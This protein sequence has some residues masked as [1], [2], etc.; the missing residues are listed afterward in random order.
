MLFPTIRKESVGVA[1]LDYVQQLPEEQLSPTGTH[2]QKT[3]CGEFLLGE[4]W[5]GWD[6]A[7]PVWA[8]AV[9]GTRVQRRVHRREEL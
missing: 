3:F 5:R 8:R 6:E 9:L 1:W 4:K 2:S 7:S